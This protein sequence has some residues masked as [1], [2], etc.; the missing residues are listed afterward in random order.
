MELTDATRIT[1]AILLF[2]LVTV[3]TGG[4]YLLRL[5][6][7]STAATEFQVSFARA[8]HAHAGVLLILS[9]LGLLYADASGL[10][11]MLG[12]LARG[13][14]P[15]AALLMPAGFFLSSVGRDRTQPNR[16]IVLVHLGAV[17]L[18]TGLIALGIGVIP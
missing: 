10:D 17:S 6:R 14:V 16:L 1:A 18:A 3:E 13:G 8:G 5:V 11:G 9:L 2:S 15:A 12:A 7:G 4:Q